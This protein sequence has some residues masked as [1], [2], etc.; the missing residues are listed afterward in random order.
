MS[1]LADTHID[2]LIH[3]ARNRDRGPLIKYLR[4]GRTVTPTLAAFLAD[5]LA[6][7]VKTP[8][9]R[10]EAKRRRK[11]AP[12]ILRGR[13]DAYKEVIARAVAD[14]LDPDQLEGLLELLKRAG[15][16]SGLVGVSL[17]KGI[18][19]TGLALMR[20]H[21]RL[22]EHE[23]SEDMYPRGKVKTMR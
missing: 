19:D 12:W 4:D 11:V 18:P 5:V 6:G 13:F 7:D 14:D 8:R 21:Y 17:R 22:K 16:P 2:H 1:D 9:R 23:L 20:Q 10:P 3:L 15:Q